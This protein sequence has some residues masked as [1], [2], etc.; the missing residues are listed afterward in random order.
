MRESSTYSLQQLPK[1][2]PLAE[3]CRRLVRQGTP[4]NVVVTGDEIGLQLSCG[5]YTVLATS[6]DYFDSCHHWIHLLGRAGKLVDQLQMPDEFGYIQDVKVVSQNEVAF[7]Y[8][9]TSDRWNLAVSDEGF[10]SYTLPSMLKR[11]NRFLFAKRHLA[12]RRMKGMR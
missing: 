7:G 9:G 11:P 8:H 2:H 5:D 1:S 6:Y 3:Y 10:W 12:A 4:L